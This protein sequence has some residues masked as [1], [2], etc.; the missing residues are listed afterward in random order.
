MQKR[1]RRA[2]GIV[3]RHRSTIEPAAR[4]SRPVRR[5]LACAAL[6]GFAMLL[7]IVPAGV[8]RADLAQDIENAVAEILNDLAGDELAAPEFSLTLDNLPLTYTV[9]GFA[10][11]EPDDPWAPPLAV[12]VPNLSIYECA[13]IATAGAVVTPDETSAAV[14]ITIAP[15]YLDLETT[16][17]RGLLCAALGDGPPNLF[18]PFYEGYAVHDGY[19]LGS[20]TISAAFALEVV[21]GCF[22]CALVPDSASLVFAPE[23]V[24]SEDACLEF[25]WNT[26]IQGQT[27]ADVVLPQVQSELDAAFAT[28]LSEAMT[29][30]SDTL[31][32]FTPDDDVSWGAVKS[33]YRPFAT[34]GG[35]R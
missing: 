17:E 18:P 4:R 33:A 19:A 13:N 24:A 30:I 15:L 23:T 27:L 3:S 29:R 9:I 11:C 12:P 8:A 31:C 5:S 26:E 20:V 34:D 1:H 22:R 28:V 16:R 7:L 21:E 32:Q 2:H 14:T 6:A 25:Y 35:A 10:F